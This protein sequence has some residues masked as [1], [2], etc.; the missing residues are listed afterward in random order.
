MPKKSPKK[1]K[2]E[3]IRKDSEATRE[4]KVKIG[5]RKAK[6]IVEIN[7][8][9]QFVRKG[10]DLLLT[11]TISLKEALCGLQFQIQLPTGRQYTIINKGLEI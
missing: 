7:N 4:G 1:T 11:K 9:T 10:L 8:N 2:K 6:I 5:K 3:V